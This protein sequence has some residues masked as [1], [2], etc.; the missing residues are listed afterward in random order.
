[1]KT[2]N[3]YFESEEEL[4]VFIVENKIKDSSSLL[5]Q[6]FTSNNDKDFINTLTTCIDTILPLSH[7]IGSTTDGEISD[8][9]VSIFKTSI[10]FTIFEKTSLI[11]HIIDDVQN[12]FEA[13][14]TLAQN[15]NTEK[16]KVIISF[17]DGLHGN[18]EEFLNGIDSIN[19]NVVVAGGMA[20]DNATFS[21]TYVFTKDKVVQ[22]AA[23]GVSLNSESL[24]IYTDYNFDWIPLGLNLKITKAVDNRVY[25]INNKTA[26]EIYAY[27]LGDE[28]ARQLPGV[29]IE[30]PLIVQRNGVNIGRAV[31]SSED[32]GS[33]VFAGNFKE[34]DIVRFGYGDSD[35]ILSHSEHTV[36]KMLNEPIESIFIY[37]C[38]ARRRFMPDL[39]EAEIKPLNN[40]APTAGFFTYGEF[41]TSTKKELLNQTMTIIGLS[42]STTGNLSVSKDAI[43]EEIFVSHKKGTLRALSH[44]LKTASQELETMNINLENKVNDEIEKNRQ[45]TKEIIKQKQL[46]E[47]IF[48]ESKDGFL[49]LEGNDI[50]ECNDSAAKMLNYQNQ[51]ELL[52]MNSVSLSPEFQPNGKTSEELVAENAKNAIANGSHTFEWIHKKVTGENIW[53]EV[54]MSYISIQGKDTFFA[55]WRDIDEKKQTE[56]ELEQL[57]KNLEDRVKEQVDE[58]NEKNEILLEQTKEKI[59]LQYA[60]EE[61]TSA[62]K[63]KSNFLANMSHEIRTPLNAILGFIDILFKAEDSQ[64]KRSQLKVI[65]DSSDDLLTIINDILD[66]SKIESGK[67]NIEEIVFEPKSP[68]ILVNELF[69]E[70]AQEKNIHINIHFVN[71]LP[72]NAYGDITRIKQVYSNIL[73]N[74]IKF[75]NENSSITINVVFLEEE[76]LLSCSIEDTGIGISDKS[77]SNIFSAFEQADTSTTRKFGGTGLGLSISKKLVTLMGGELSVVS[78]FGEGSTFSF[79]LDIFS[80]IPDC[81]ESDN[82][83]VVEDE[84]V[85][86]TGKVLLVEDNKSNQMLMEILLDEYG[87]EVVIANDG[88]EAIEAFKKETFSIILMDENM[89]NMN[90]IEATIQIRKLEQGNK[91][92]IVAVTANALSGE[93]ERFLDAGMDDYVSKPIDSLELKRVLVRF[94]L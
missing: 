22:N 16:T 1:M 11:T 48:K 14:K 84:E 49:V 13:G 57:R 35:A 17:I 71:E 7:L 44:L 58:L 93:R 77:I 79:T 3:T 62:N 69:Y 34:G 76:K 64:T 28:T 92:P 21:A 4:R 54:T 31:L 82:D 51:D 32:D 53:I 45:K 38:M 87:L 9:V 59:E 68:F 90:G 61:A 66:F 73:S 42:E 15:L 20:G 91:T 70:K 23:V 47:T 52:K 25:T 30:F 29:G 43:D 18:G 2:F 55:L 46:F 50:L 37:S 74:A 56:F 72:Q 83:E 80:N 67:F 85:K 41:F 94:C 5:I 39:I 27:Y 88:L 6:V 19:K 89:P 86:L 12:Y 75:S 63:A 10:S 78:K 33:L 40:I 36:E 81:I 60:E 8:G 65:K 26:Y 24:N